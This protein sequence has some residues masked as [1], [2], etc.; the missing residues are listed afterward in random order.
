MGDQ[1]LERLAGILHLHPDTERNNATGQQGCVCKDC[2]LHL[3]NI[4]RMSQMFIVGAATAKQSA[5][6][7]R[8]CTYTASHHKRYHM[9]PSPLLFWH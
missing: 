8:P 1:R 9:T 4:H 2:G 5:Q 6:Q 7:E 3:V